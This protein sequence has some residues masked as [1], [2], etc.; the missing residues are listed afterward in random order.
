MC[1]PDKRNLI[2]ASLW[3]FSFCVLLA[4]S[5]VVTDP[6]RDGEF[7]SRP[8]WQWVVILAPILPG[9]M[10]IPLWH[11]FLKNAEELIK[12]IYT[13]AAATGFA[14][15]LI[16]FLSLGFIGKIFGIEDSND[17]I[18]MAFCFTVFCFS[19]SLQYRLRKY[20]E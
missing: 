16:V 2:K 1:G 5:A 9:I 20:N 15:F 3:T 18:T 7:L 8:W 11:R 12:R 4:I 14:V 6:P 13:E 10:A 17:T 19:L